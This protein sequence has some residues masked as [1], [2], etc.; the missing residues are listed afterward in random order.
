M[1]FC[2]F[3]FYPHKEEEMKHLAVYLR[4]WSYFA[5][6]CCWT[7]SE[8]CRQ[9][10][11]DNGMVSKT[12][13]KVYYLGCLGKLLFISKLINSKSKAGFFNTFTGDI[14]HYRFITQ[15]KAK[16]LELVFKVLE[17]LLKESV[18]GC[19]KCCRVFLFF[20]VNRTAISTHLLIFWGNILLFFGSVKKRLNQ[21]QV[22]GKLFQQFNIIK[23][24]LTVIKEFLVWHRTSL[25]LLLRCGLSTDLHF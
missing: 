4:C 21:C 24:I 3:L 17:N 7:S 6:H 14:V 16:K 12:L 9:Q 23:D 22:I 18:A 5:H 11:N 20:E 2:C 8:T 25:A 13:L 1:H 10:K 19:W 15:A